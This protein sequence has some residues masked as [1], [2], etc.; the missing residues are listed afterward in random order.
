[1]NKASRF[2]VLKNY[3]LGGHGY[4]SDPRSTGVH[5]TTELRQATRFATKALANK[6][7]DRWDG[8][9]L[10][11]VRVALIDAPQLREWRDA[12]RM[13]QAELASYLGVA[14][15]TIARWERGEMQIERP[16]MVLSALEQ[17]ASARA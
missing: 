13:T 1:M 9:T 14:P 16:E 15:N 11:P 3:T 10:R 2:Y 8:Y 17:L 4:V 7:A 6:A 12:L 5:F